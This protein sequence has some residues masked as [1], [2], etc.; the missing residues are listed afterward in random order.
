MSPLRQL[1]ACMVASGVDTI[2]L[3]NQGHLQGS[4]SASPPLSS[5]NM[6]PTEHAQALHRNL[7]AELIHAGAGRPPL[8]PSRIRFPQEPG[9]AVSINSPT[10]SWRNNLTF[11]SQDDRRTVNALREKVQKFG[12]ACQATVAE[13]LQSEAFARAESARVQQAAADLERKQAANRQALAEEI[14]E[15]RLQKKAASSAP[16]ALAPGAPV[17]A[18]DMRFCID[19][20]EA[21][22]KEAGD[23][24]LS[25]FSDFWT[26]DHRKMIPNRPNTFVPNHLVKG[27]N[28]LCGLTR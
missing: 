19:N 10:V 5:F 26:P 3:G 4:S 18:M 22:R 17:P 24:N 15:T 21:I 20:L 23:F 25:E 11:S 27:S 1:V 8:L 2:Q 9:P 13:A 6:P 16:A 28:P 14:R 7:A 12:E